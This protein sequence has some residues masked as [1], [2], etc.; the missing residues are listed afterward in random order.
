MPRLCELNDVTKAPSSLASDDVSYVNGTPLTV[1]GGATIYM[2]SRGVLN[3]D[4]G[5][6]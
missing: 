4:A 3:R 1:E 2:R 5:S 6:P